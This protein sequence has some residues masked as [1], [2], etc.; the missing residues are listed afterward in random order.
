MVGWYFEFALFVSYH[1]SKFD[2]WD[3]IHVSL[4]HWNCYP[5]G[6]W[7]LKSKNTILWWGVGF[8]RLE[9]NLDLIEEVRTSIEMRFTIYK[10]KMAHYFNKIIKGRQF[11]TG[12][13]VFRKVEIIGH[14]LK[15]LD[16]S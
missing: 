4:W 7:N 5:S 2:E 13:L 8:V 9:T 10:H 6:D 3:P 12:D 16:L 14:T 15:R 1:K 11:Y